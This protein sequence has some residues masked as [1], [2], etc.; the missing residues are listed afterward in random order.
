MNS[1]ATLYIVAMLL[2]ICVRRGR[3]A[4]RSSAARVKL[5]RKMRGL[6]GRIMIRV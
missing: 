2:P 4:A 3:A 5:G 6:C 1:H